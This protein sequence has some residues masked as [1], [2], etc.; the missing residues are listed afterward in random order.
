MLPLAMADAKA[1]TATASTA[2]ATSQDPPVAKY[3]WRRYHNK[4]EACPTYSKATGDYNAM[5]STYPAVSCTGVLMRFTSPSWEPQGGWIP[6]PKSVPGGSV[7]GGGVS[8]VYI[9]TD[10]KFVE[11]PR[12]WP[13]GFTLYP[14]EGKYG[15]PA[16]KQK[17]VVLCAYPRDGS[18][19]YRADSGCAPP[20]AKADAIYWYQSWITSGNNGQCSFDLRNSGTSAATFK[21][22]ML[23]VTPTIMGSIA[24]QQWNELRLQTWGTD[25]ESS[26]KL[27]LE[28]FFYM[29]GNATGLANAQF[30]QQKYYQLTLQFVPIV[31]ITSPKSVGDDYNFAFHSADQKVD[32]PMFDPPLPCSPGDFDPSNLRC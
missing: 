23:A 28:S 11:A 24:G 1:A 21:Q 13:N 32:I 20:C 26:K 14:R 15:T 4:S 6:E 8:F 17:A 7:S 27:A 3:M 2:A 10:A 25:D 12:S 22:F 18:T 19:D 9:R 31:E 29:D 30:D 5:A 16:G